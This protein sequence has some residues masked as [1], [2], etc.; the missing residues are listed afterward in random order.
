MRQTARAKVESY[1]S[2]CCRATIDSAVFSD[3]RAFLVCS[4]CGKVLAVE[5]KGERDT[6]YPESADQAARALSR[7]RA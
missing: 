2:A 5:P 6:A 1:R 7:R 3:G 4:A